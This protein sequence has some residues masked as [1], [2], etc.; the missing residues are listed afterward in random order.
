MLRDNKE[1]S[2]V[3]SHPHN[4]FLLLEILIYFPLSLLV[5]QVVTFY[6]PVNVSSTQIVCLL[7]S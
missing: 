2:K 7:E 6:S 3:S 1:I 4:L 5:F